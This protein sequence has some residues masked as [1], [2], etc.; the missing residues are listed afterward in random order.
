ME[1]IRAAMDEYKTQLQNGAIQTAYKGI[2][3][4]IMG[5]RTY[6]EKKYPDFSVPGSI[7][8]GYMDMTYFALVPKSLKDRK[9]KIAI[10]FL[11]KEF[12]FEVWLSGVNKQVQAEYWKVFKESGWDQYRLVPSLQ[13]EDAIIE[14]ILVEDPNFCDAEGLTGQI[15]IGTLKFISSVEAFLVEYNR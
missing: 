2:M 4:F 9:L 15:E 1:S 5:L 7:Y 13:G 8:Y 11:H 3:E 14:W 10:V 12:R 6:F